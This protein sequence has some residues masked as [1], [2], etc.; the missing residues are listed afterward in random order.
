MHSEQWWE[1]QAPAHITRCTSNLKSGGRCRREAAPG[2][3]VCDRHGAN[4]PVVQQA[5]AR[6]IGMSLDDAV[7][8]LQA[9]LDDDSVEAR[10]KVKILHDLL[11][12]GGLGATS[13]VLVGVG[14]V[15]PIET[16]FRDLLTQPG[17]LAD[18]TP[19]PPAL[20]VPDAAQAALDARQADPDWATVLGREIGSDD[21]DDVVDAELVEDRPAHTVYEAEPYRTPKRIRDDL[22]RLI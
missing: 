4:L 22:K 3:P 9:M 20:P 2:A 15:D 16:L 21:A 12:R 7:K 13:K 11:D 19:Q 18:P 5:A 10:D 8:R 17:A 1:T 14:H 6:R